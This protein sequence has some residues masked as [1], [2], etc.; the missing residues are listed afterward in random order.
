MLILE[1]EICFDRQNDNLQGL[2]HD[3]STKNII[4]PAINFGNNLL[5]SGTIILV[6][7]NI[8][9]IKRGETYNVMIEMP[10]IEKE[11]YDAISLLLHSGDDFKMQN[12]SI[13]IGKGKILDFLY[14]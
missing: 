11:A 12:A 7:K 13:I 8:D 1:A 10:T 14:E 9:I 2:P 5:F 6:D 3:L 4:R